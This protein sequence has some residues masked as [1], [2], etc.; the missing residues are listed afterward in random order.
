MYVYASVVTEVGGIG[1]DGIIAV[2]MVKTAE[3]S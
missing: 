1:G 3:V 2:V